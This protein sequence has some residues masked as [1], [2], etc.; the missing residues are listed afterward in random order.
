MS[1]N[2]KL[3]AETSVNEEAGFAVTTK[4]FT[5]RVVG[6]IRDIK[7]GIDYN[8]INF[9]YFNYVRQKVEGIEVEA[10]YKPIEMLMV[11]ANYTYLSPEETTQ[12]RKTNKDTLTYSYLLRRPAHN[13]NFTVGVTPIPSLYVAV[14][15]KYVSS[16][17]DFGGYKA[18][19]VKLDDYFILGAYGEYSY[20]KQLKFFMNLQNLANRKFYDVYGYNS[21]PFMIQGGITLS[22]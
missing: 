8:Y 2:S 21:I 18:A 14:T 17:Y 13:I 10:T 16:R 20:M 12:N 9:N 4:K 6:F 5:G 11:T 22:L 15:G 1:N 3:N 19:D 7:N